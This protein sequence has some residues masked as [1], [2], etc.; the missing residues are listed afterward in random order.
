MDEE[1]QEQVPQKETKP[2]PEETPKHINRDF[3]YIW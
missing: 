1:K 2:E 3:Y